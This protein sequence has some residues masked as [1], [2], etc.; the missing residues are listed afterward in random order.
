MSVPSRALTKA[1]STK[2]GA[3]YVGNGLDL[4]RSLRPASVALVLTSPPFALTRPKA[5][6]NEGIDDYIKWFMPFSRLIYRVLKPNGSF[7]LDLGGSWVPGRPIRNVYQFQLLLELVQARSHR[8]V[9]AEEFYW[10][11]R[12]RL[13]GPIEWVNVQRIRVTDAVNVVWWLAKT[14]RPFADN[15][16]VLRPYSPSQ[17]K[18]FETGYNSGARPSEWNIG[19]TSFSRDNGGS[20]PSNFIRGD[21][22]GEA[23]YGYPATLAPQPT[24]L[25]AGSNTASRD[26]Y[27]KACRE[28]G[29]TI[30]PARFPVHFASFFVRFLTRE[31]DVVVDPFAG[32]NTTGWAAQLSGRRWRAADLDRDYVAGSAARFG[33]DPT[34]VLRKSQASP[35]V[36][37]TPTSA[38]P[39]RRGR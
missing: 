24:N 1:Y 7:V 21:D 36:R 38:R 4:L 39:L 23:E 19:R 25:L 33:L 10:L 3:A 11:N 15:T 29:L 9:L 20:I 8:F 30:H 32:S 13:P 6:G 5:Y 31:N 18:L 26:P 34:L 28:L 12:A 22:D 2:L 16:A 17:L 35:G 14:D 37:L 27:L